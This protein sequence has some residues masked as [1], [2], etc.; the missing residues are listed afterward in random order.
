MMKLPI[1][2]SYDPAHHADPMPAAGDP[3]DVWVWME[4]LLSS[5]Q[6]D[7]SPPPSKREEG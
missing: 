2:G 5:G 6:A 7:V 1:S 4:D 3:D